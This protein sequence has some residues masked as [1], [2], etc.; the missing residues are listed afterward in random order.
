MFVLEY[1]DQPDGDVIIRDFKMLGR[2][3][4]GAP[5]VKGEI[6]LVSGC[7]DSLACATLDSASASYPQ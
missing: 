6:S 3:N 5:V 1:T 2:T 7:M 4:Q